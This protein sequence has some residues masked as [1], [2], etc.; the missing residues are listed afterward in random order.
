VEWNAVPSS[1][2]EALIQNI[3]YEMR[4]ELYE[5]Q[6]AKR[7]YID[8]SSGGKRPLGIPTLKDRVVQQVVKL[9]IEPIFESN[10]LDCSIG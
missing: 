6:P 1:A 4:N 7:V 5:P 3:C 9:I 8:K 2:K 10:F